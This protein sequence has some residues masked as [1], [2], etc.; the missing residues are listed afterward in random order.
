MKI[1][2][3]RV[4]ELIKEEIQKFLKEEVDKVEFNKARRAINKARSQ[5]L[6]DGPK[7]K[8]LRRLAYKDPVAAMQGLQ[9]SEPYD[10][11]KPFG[12]PRDDKEFTVGLGR[13]KA[14]PVQRLDPPTSTAS[15]KKAAADAKKMAAAAGEGDSAKA[16]KNQRLAKQYKNRQMDALRKGTITDPKIATKLVRAHGG[17][18][19]SELGITAG[20]IDNPAV[21]KAIVAAAMA[22]RKTAK[23]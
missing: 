9:P 1:K 19:F 23:K 7:W 2:P 4:K 16:A 6:I 22:N 21:L 12:T 8:K 10:R 11:D 3:S 15:A 5:N 14:T 17:K 20:A 18:N 13:K